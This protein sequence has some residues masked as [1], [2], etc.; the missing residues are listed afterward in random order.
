MAHKLFL[1]IEDQDAVEAGVM[2]DDN[3][4]E[5]LSERGDESWNLPAGTSSPDI[6][7]DTYEEAA[8][9]RTW[10]IRLYP[11]RRVIKK[12][13]DLL[14][15]LLELNDGEEKEESGEAQ[16]SPEAG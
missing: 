15:L 16:G 10:L 2:S 9:A 13:M 1:E 11:Y 12:T 8:A 4:S 5:A 3:N 6:L 7:F 14:T